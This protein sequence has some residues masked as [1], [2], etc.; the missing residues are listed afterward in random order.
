MCMLVRGDIQFYIDVSI[1]ITFFLYNGEICKT[2][3][4]FGTKNS[5]FLDM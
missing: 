3:P 4:L 1:N 5:R 2:E